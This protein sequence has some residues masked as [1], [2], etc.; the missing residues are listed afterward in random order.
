VSPAL[1]LAASLAAIVT[2]LSCRF[3]ASAGHRLRSHKNHAD[4]IHREELGRFTSAAFVIALIVIAVLAMLVFLR[5]RSEVIAALGVQ[6][7][8][9]AL[10]I[11]AGVAVRREDR[12]FSSLVWNRPGRDGR[13]LWG[14]RLA[15][16]PAA[17]DESAGR[18]MS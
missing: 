9:T 10:M 2:V 11:A 13:Q 12:R 3:L 14:H 17:L 1:A 15:F 16:G 4:T 5:F 8:L 7:Q 18:A 6:A